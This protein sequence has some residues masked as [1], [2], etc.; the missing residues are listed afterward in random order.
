MVVFLSHKMSSV[1]EEVVLDIR[2]RA[3]SFIREKLPEINDIEFI[4]NYIYD[5]APED[6]TNLWYLGRSIQEMGKADL[7]FF[8]HDP[9]EARGCKVECLISDLY[10]LP[11]LNHIIG[12]LPE[13]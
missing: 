1:S 10:D 5:D 4:E 7:I 3:M 9:R 12:D 6:A 11:I 13:K 2:T 8:C